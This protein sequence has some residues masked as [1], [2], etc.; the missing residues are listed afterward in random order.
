MEFLV[1]RYVVESWVVIFLV[2]DVVDDG[3][4]DMIMSSNVGCYG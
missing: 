4:I 2:F 3:M 1:Y